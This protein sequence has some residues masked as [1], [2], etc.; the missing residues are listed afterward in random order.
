MKTKLPAPLALKKFIVQKA[1]EIAYNGFNYNGPLETK[2]EIE[3]A[4]AY[5]VD[6]DSFGI[7]SEVRYEGLETD[8]PAPISRHYECEIRALKTDD[9]W[10]GYN[11]WHGGGKHG[12]P[13]SI[14]WIS[15]SYY[16]TCEEK[17]VLTIQRTWA[18]V[19]Q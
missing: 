9:G 17:E 14:D 12:A 7:K 4:Y 2:Q 1:N 18:K 16:L 13:E 10:I 5:T 8:L 15:D 11:F 19:I 3:D 6:N